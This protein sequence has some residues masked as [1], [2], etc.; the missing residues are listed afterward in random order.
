MKG[1]KTQNASSRMSAMQMRLMIGF[2]KRKDY[3]HDF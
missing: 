1:L 3:N 2:R